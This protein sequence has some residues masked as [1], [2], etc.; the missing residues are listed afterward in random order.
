MTGFYSN[1]EIKAHA[2]HVTAPEITSSQL[3]KIRD[4]NWKSNVTLVGLISVWGQKESGKTGQ[5]RTFKIVTCMFLASAAA[6]RLSAHALYVEETIDIRHC[7]QNSW[8]QSMR[9][10]ADTVTLAPFYF[11]KL[12]LLYTRMDST[13]ARVSLKQITKIWRI[14]LHKTVQKTKQKKIIKIAPWDLKGC[15]E[16]ASPHRHPL[17]P[18]EW[19]KKKGGSETQKLMEVTQRRW[20]SKMYNDQQK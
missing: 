10:A 16:K 13:Q 12:L 8:L 20:G 14:R 15:R 5:W 11:L 2:S 1:P 17:M 4:F 9:R 3:L 19:G 18:W 6:A 7:I